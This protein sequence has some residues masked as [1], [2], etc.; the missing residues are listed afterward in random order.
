ME[1]GSKNW[2]IRFK[3]AIP[4]ANEFCREIGEFIIFFQINVFPEETALKNYPNRSIR[5]H[6]T[7]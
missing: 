5:G 6:Q 2:P 3:F 1:V 7:D 4:K